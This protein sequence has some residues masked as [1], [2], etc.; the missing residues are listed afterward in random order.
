MLTDQFTVRHPA[1]AELLQGAL[2]GESLAV[3]KVFL[4]LSSANPNLR[5]LMQ[6]SIHDIA[7]ENLWQHLLRCLA[8]HCWEEYQ[9]SIQR[10]DQE[11][12]QRIDQSI[13]EVFSQDEYEA[14]HIFKETI[15]YTSLDDS[16]P[17]IRYAATYLLGLR[18]VVEVIPLLENILDTAVKSWKVR[19]MRSLA[20]IKDERC[21]DP[22]IK[23]LEMDR[24]V[25][26][27]AAKQALI[28]LGPLAEKTWVAALNHPDSHIRWHAARSLSDPTDRRSMEMLAEG[29]MDENREVRL[30]S[31]D[32]LARIGPP[33][34]PATLAVISRNEL[35]INARKAACQALHGVY[36][37]R[38]RE[39][40]KPLLDALQN[41]SA[42]VEAPAIAF[43]LLKEWES[44]LL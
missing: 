28:E 16:R 33:G 41:S 24:G 32:T 6:E 1:E 12:W 3:N 36:S 9:D 19:A 10:V 2:T 43:R 23:A 5:Q 40:L 42:S 35:N 17:E 27:S 20:A 4:Y 34:V 39:R 11:S 30:A 14:E 29:L 26:H 38:L 13:T 25:L 15:L 31:A 21:G 8:I 7:S 37:R 18:G 44:G 22:L